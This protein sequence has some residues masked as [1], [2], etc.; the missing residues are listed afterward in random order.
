MREENI[1]KRL[2]VR[3]ITLCSLFAALSA[4]G[5]F[6]RIPI[7]IVP[8]TLQFFF[9]ALAGI[10]LGSKKGALSQL[11][12]VLVGL[13]GVPVFTKGGG[14]HYVLEPTFGY[15]LGFIVG[16]YVIGKC[17]EKLQTISIKNIFISSML[18]LLVVYIF[19]VVYMYFIYNFYIGS[20]LGIW[21]AIVSGAIS[22][23]PG[24]ILLCIITAVVGA[25][26]VPVLRNNRFI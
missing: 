6:I 26:V 16:A 15:L 8:F 1:K 18:G 19:G 17:M 25:N 23:A 3:T 4:I 10:L 14:L 13:A 12:Y 7:P 20:E 24:D 2:D 5:A 11:I 22:C 9:T 21:A